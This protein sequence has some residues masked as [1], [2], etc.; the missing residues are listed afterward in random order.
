MKKPDEKWDLGNL[1]EGCRTGSPDNTLQLSSRGH[2][3]ESPPGLGWWSPPAAAVTRR[4]GGGV[5][6][7]RGGKASPHN[8]GTC[9]DAPS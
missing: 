6:G 4:E 2:E 5:S 1:Q 8:E 3:P 9:L 7:L